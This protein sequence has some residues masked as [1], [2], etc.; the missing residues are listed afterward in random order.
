MGPGVLS[1]PL[2]PHSHLAYGTWEAN[3]C[4]SCV[5]LGRKGSEAVMKS[6]CSWDG[7]VGLES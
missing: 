4:E 2:F 3:R 7:L 1:E 6:L 5:L